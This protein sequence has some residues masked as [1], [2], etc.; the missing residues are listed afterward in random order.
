MGWVDALKGKTIGLDT[1]PLIYFIEEQSQFFEIVLPFFQAMDQG[2]ISVVTSTITLLEVL[3]HPLRHA[4]H[5]LA[6]RYKTTLLAAKGLDII[7]LSPLISE[8]AAELRA[9]YNLSTP[10]AIQIATSLESGAEF[11]LT[12]DF[13]LAKVS[14]IKV[15]AVSKLE[16]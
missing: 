7:N 10:D 2:D 15:I 14:E 4:N 8:K 16:V 9:R 13:A 6:E 12:N 5:D 3:V 1:A 11:F